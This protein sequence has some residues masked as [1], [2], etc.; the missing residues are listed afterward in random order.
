M[1]TF[2]YAK[3]S[4]TAQD[5]Q[6]V[7]DALHDQHITRG[8]KV[9]AFEAAI[10][11]Y[12]GAQY[13]VAFNSGTT[14]LQAACYAANVRSSDRVITTPNSFVATLLAGTQRGAPA[15]FVDID[16]STGNLDIHQVEAI[17]RE[18]KLTRGRHIIL[19]VHFSGIPVDMELLDR[20]ICT[21]DVVVIED[22]AHALG[23]TYRSGERVGS[24]A[25]SQMT[26][27]SFHPAKIITTGEGGMILT[28]D[29]ELYHRLTLFRN[30]GIS[31]NEKEWS[32]NRATCY[33]G[34]YEVQ[35]TTGNYNFTDFQAALGLS[36]LERI[37]SLILKRRALVATYRKLLA[38][39][40]H[41]R[42][43]T[44]EEDSRTAFHLFVIQI[45]YTAYRTTRAHVIQALSEKGIG[46]QVH[47]IPLYRHPFYAKKYPD[48]E[49]SFPEMEKYYEST[50]SL[51]LYSDLTQE[52]VAYV[53]STL[54]EIL[55]SARVEASHHVFKGKRGK[56]RSG[57]NQ[58][59]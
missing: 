21:P 9:A 46:S 49:L 54:K 53:V 23:S 56:S 27:F 15:R 32:A 22:A 50:L 25:W 6:S 39:L 44:S 30:N 7:V 26:M 10:A 1:S 37:D 14:A 45:D 11:A 55:V 41:T 43:F 34:Y 8:P 57:P 5:I 48:L 40:P 19:P 33:P 36:Q 13:A 42:L 20:L 4:I 24:C 35:E 59:F 12:C 2:P 16:R 18:E 51:P 52:N 58:K 29:P 38:D 17:L 28:N 3:Q 31:K 47:Y